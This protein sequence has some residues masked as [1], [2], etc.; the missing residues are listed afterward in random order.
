MRVCMCMCTCAWY[1][2]L[3]ARLVVRALETVSKHAEDRL[4]ASFI[5][6]IL[7][8]LLANDGDGDVKF[9]VKEAVAAL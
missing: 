9:Y 7:N 4:V 1:L 2:V 6:P 5:K 3:A 8:E